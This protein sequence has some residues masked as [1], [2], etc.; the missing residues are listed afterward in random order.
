MQKMRSQTYMMADNCTI[1]KE[2][3]CI[4][5]YPTHPIR[6]NMIVTLGRRNFHDGGGESACHRNKA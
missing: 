5:V 3:S 2:I 1:V 4:Y 6:T